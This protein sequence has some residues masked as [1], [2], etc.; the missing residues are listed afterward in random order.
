MVIG[1]GIEKDINAAKMF[2]IFLLIIGLIIG[3]AL[4]FIGLMG[5]NLP[6]LFTGMFIAYM[7]YDLLTTWVWFDEL[8]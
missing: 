3:F 2:F 1:R 6:Q 5:E 7:S 4:L 8:K